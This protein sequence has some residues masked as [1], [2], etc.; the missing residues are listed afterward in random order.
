MEVTVLG[1]RGGYPLVGEPCSGYLLE[2]AGTRLWVDAGSGTLDALLRRLDPWELDA[3]WVSHLHPDHWTDLPIAL[4]R[5]AVTAHLWDRPPPLVFGPP[6]W[7]AT[8]GIASQA[9]PDDRIP[10]RSIDL[11]D[12]AS[13]AVGSL[14]LT[15]RAVAHSGPTFGLR[16]DGP[17]GSFAYSADSSP[18]DAV[19]DLA[20]E[21]D[22]FICE[23]TLPPG[24][25]NPIST[26]ADEAGR[27]AD[28]AGADRLVLTHLLE[29]VDRD[30][31]LDAASAQHAGTTELASPGSTFV[32]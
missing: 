12:G 10:Y 8:I 29:G 26:S 19:R 16:V 2:A 13:H 15:A 32:T 4:H 20:A 27:L 1:C 17:S 11:A 22:L 14:R 31:S 18:C 3:I 7:D 24:R 5:M 30:R 28:A 9:Y 6:A 23:A 21:A 25:S